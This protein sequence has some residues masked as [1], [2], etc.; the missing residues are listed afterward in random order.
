MQA[1]LNFLLTKKEISI[2]YRRNI[3]S[4][5]KKSL[6]DANEKYLTEFYQKGKYKPFTWNVFLNIENISND[7]IYLKDNE[8]SVFFSSSDTRLFYLFTNAFLEQRKKPFKIQNENYMILTNIEEI[9][10]KNI[11]NNN[12]ICKTASPICIIHQENKFLT[13]EDENFI[14]TFKEKTGLDFT[15]IDCKKRIVKH[16]NIQFPTTVGTFMLSGPINLLNKYYQ[17]GICDKHNQGFGNF[18]II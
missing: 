11:T 13:F 18:N 16:Y 2:E 17:D 3:I 10:Q 4:F 8:M 1:K 15:P 14:E 7:K 5:I 6:S 12:V 9:K